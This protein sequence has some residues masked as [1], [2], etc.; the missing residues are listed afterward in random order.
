MHPFSQ[1]SAPET[2]LDIRLALTNTIYYSAQAASAFI[3]STPAKWE[4]AAIDFNMRLDFTDNCWR[5]FI[6]IINIAIFIESDL[7]LSL[8]LCFEW[9]DSSHLKW[10]NRRTYFLIICMLHGRSS[11]HKSIPIDLF[12]SA[13]LHSKSI[14]INGQCHVPFLMLTS[15]SE[16]E[17][18]APS[19][20]A[21]NLTP[22][23]LNRCCVH[24]TRHTTF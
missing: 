5:R 20:P 15:V 7:I 14:Q 8:P 11:V 12:S 19:E 18:D 21:N 3:P 1:Q 17:I 13:I 24:W 23:Y 9:T 4:M 2:D 6:R 22:H 10:N 16:Q